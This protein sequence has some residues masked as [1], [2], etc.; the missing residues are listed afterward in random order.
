MDKKT[1]EIEN[2]KINVDD[3]FS[4]KN[5]ERFSDFFRVMRF[6]PLIPRGST[7]TSQSQSSHFK[8]F[9][10]VKE[11]KKCNFCIV[12]KVFSKAPSKENGKEFADAS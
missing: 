2:E 5:V 7:N 10:M 8:A 3:P 1:L 12:C 11:S 9:T 4:Q 6:S